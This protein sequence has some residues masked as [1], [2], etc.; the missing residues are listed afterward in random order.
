MKGLLFYPS[1]TPANQLLQKLNQMLYLKM[2]A[3]FIPEVE[4]VEEESTV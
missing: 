1:L 3:I 4:S 2:E